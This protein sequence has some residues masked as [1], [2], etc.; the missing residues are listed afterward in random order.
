[1]AEQTNAAGLWS[2]RDKNART[3]RREHEMVDGTRYLL[4]AQD[5]SPVKPHHAALFLR[6]PSF[7]VR[8]ETG[9]PQVSLPEAENIDAA[10]RRPALEPDETIAK[11][12]ELMRP[13]LMARAMQRPGGSKLKDASRDELIEFLQTAPTVAD[14]PVAERVRDTGTTDPDELSAAEAKKV[15]GDAG[16]DALLATG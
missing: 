5:W 2:V 6:D 12:G 8:D 10:R 7:E 4:D 11:Y 3:Q 16:V 13:A 1:M 14:L 9:E 15:L